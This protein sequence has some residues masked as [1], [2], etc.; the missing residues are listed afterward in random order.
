M[1][2]KKQTCRM[3]L[4]IITNK[5]CTCLLNLPMDRLI[6]IDIIPDLVA[7]EYIFEN[8]TGAFSYVKET[9]NTQ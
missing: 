2:A 6:S 5:G 8:I 7:K 4:K 1:Y 3:A 9:I